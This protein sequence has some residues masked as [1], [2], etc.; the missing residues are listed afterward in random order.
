MLLI[1]PLSLAALYNLWK[2]KY[3]ESL[4]AVYITCGTVAKMSRPGAFLTGDVLCLCSLSSTISIRLKET[5]SDFKQ[6]NA[7]T[8]QFY[9]EAVIIYSLL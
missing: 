1:P 5:T 7:I 9:R 4:A 8:S 2:W 6:L 3:I